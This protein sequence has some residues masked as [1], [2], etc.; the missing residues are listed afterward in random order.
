MTSDSTV[1]VVRRTMAYDTL[2]RL[3]RAFD[4][5]NDSATRY[6]YDSLRL[7][8]VKDPAGNVY[9]VK[10]NAVGLAVA[11]TDPT[12]HSDT[13]QYDVEGLLRR[14][15][16]RRGQRSP[17]PMTPPIGCAPEGGSGILADTVMI[18]NDSV[19]TIANSAAAETRYVNRRGQND[20]VK[21]VLTIPGTGAQTYWQRFRY[22]TN[23]LL[24][25]VWI[26]GTHGHVPDSPIRL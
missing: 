16:N 10:Y 12:G 9:A 15:V 7:I 24:D 25:S 17:T 20:S 19:A 6:S 3:I 5:V 13:L 11:H 26:A 22:R 14:A 18:L 21:T 8:R 23:G 4:G 1:G 2:N